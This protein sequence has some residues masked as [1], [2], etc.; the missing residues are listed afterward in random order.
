[1]ASPLCGLLPGVR[2]PPAARAASIHLTFGN[3]LS[4]FVFASVSVLLKR[5]N[6]PER[7]EK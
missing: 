6:G 7:D 3:L 1:M 2:E 5:L 4:L